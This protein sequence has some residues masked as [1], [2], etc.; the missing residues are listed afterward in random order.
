M[1]EI[2]EKEEE[3]GRGMGGWGGMGAQRPVLSPT[4]CEVA[5]SVL[6]LVAPNGGANIG[7][8]YRTHIIVFLISLSSAKDICN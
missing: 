5:D 6:G 2:I 3:E 4:K 1:R 8:N 7:K